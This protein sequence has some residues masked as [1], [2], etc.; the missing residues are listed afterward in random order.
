[1]PLHVGCCDDQGG[2]KVRVKWFGD[3]SNLHKVW[4]ADMI[5]QSKFSFTELAEA[6][7][8]P[9]K[10]A[11]SHLQQTSVLDWANESMSY[12]KQV[13]EIGEGN[14]GYKYTYYNFPTVRKRLVEAGV[15][16]AGILNQIYG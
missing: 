4:D 15:R 9:D 8:D 16:L 2:N 12:R 5:D 6:L 3:P 13:Y 10:P 14:L 7:E 1:M 11:V